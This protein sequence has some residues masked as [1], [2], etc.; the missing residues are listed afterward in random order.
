MLK[1][2]EKGMSITHFGENSNRVTVFS[3]RR[4]SLLL[5]V[6][7]KLRRNLGQNSSP[8]TVPQCDSTQTDPVLMRG[9]KMVNRSVDLNEHAHKQK[10][11]TERSPPITV[12]TM[13]S[14]TVSASPALAMAAWEPPL[15][16]KKPKNKMNPPKAACCN[17][18]NKTIMTYS[19][20]SANCQLGY[21]LRSSCDM[22]IFFQKW[23]VIML[24]L[25]FKTS[26]AT[27]T[28]NVTTTMSTC[29]WSLIQAKAEFNSLS[30]I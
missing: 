9:L 29:S 19:S 5:L 13:A 23:G 8:K 17:Q 2:N 24:N 28:R 26:K 4:L 16:A 11:W 27:K 10:Y 22:S 7:T 6:I 20:T 30:L 21:G 3:P 12:L 1:S 15:N 18:G 25:I 14:A